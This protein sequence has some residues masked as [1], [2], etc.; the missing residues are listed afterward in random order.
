MS[1]NIHHLSGNLLVGSSHLFV[2]TTNNRV[3]ITTANPDAGLHVNSNAYVDTNFRVGS[4]IAMNVTGGRITAGSFEGDGS[5]LSGVNSDSGSWVNG[6]SSNI[7]LAVSGDNVGIGKDN[8]SHK[9]DV[10]GD[11]NISSGSTLRVGG[12]PAVFSNWSVDGSDIY[13]SSGN[14]GIG[15]VSPAT[16]LHLSAKNSDPGATEGDNIGSHNLVEYLRFTSTSD[17]GDINAISTGF[18]LGE[19]DTSSSPVGRL[20]I[21]ANSYA[22]AGN[23]YGSTPDVTVATF[24]GSGNV[25]I[26]VT[27]PDVKLH[28]AGTGAII[29]PSGTTSQRPSGTIDG[30]LRVN[31]E[32]GFLEVYKGGWIS[33]IPDDPSHSHTTGWEIIMRT[34]GKKNQQGNTSTNS[35]FGYPG[36][37]NF[38]SITASS[39]GA[40]SRTSFGD[41]VGLYDAFFNKTGITKIA[42]VSG[43]GNNIDMTSHSQYIIY[44]LVESSGSESLY[45]IIKRL[46]EYNRVNASWGNNDSLFGASSVI[47]FTA[48]TNGYS[49][50]RSSYVS[51]GIRD[52]AGAIPEKFCIWGIN[53]DS[54]NDTQVLCAYSGNLASGKGDQWRGGQPKQSFWSYWGNDWHSNSVS[55]TIGSSQQSTP[56]IGDSV[57]TYTGDIYLMAF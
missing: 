57:T 6:S 35:S 26:G 19:G 30:M 11:I 18:K 10:D 7:H 22:D 52:E 37:N 32:T 36:S 34:S 1:E 55:L 40:S 42:L 41:A 39:T 20:D 54:D 5:L 43:N 28:V 49:G 25:G 9:L 46:D 44:D 45:D 51:S 31:T 48:G 3:G 15:T 16:Y 14:V 50:T 2:D 24:L 21:C 53:R 4:G 23:S 38:R 47:N 27:N 13:R 29:I 8:P 12:T 56:G 33:V 17:S